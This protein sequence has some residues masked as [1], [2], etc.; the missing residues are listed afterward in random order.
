M[1]V[2]NSQHILP[3]RLLCA[4]AATVNLK[5]SPLDLVFIPPAVYYCTEVSVICLDWL[6]VFNSC[7]GLL[8]SLVT[9]FSCYLYFFRVDQ[10]PSRRLPADIGSTT[11]CYLLLAFCL[12]ITCN[13]PV[14]LLLRC[15]VFPRQ[16]WSKTYPSLQGQVPLKGLQWS[17]S[18]SKRGG[19][20]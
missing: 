3:G 9:I 13:H 20:G 18:R 1:G 5:S 8:A 14:S 4:F 17:L 11:I 2:R 10:C 7:H 6:P 16:R 15:T 19:N 12:F